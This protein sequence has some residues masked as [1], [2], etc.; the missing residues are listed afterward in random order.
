MPMMRVAH[1]LQGWLLNTFRDPTCALRFCTQ[2]DGLPIYVCLGRI[3]FDA[4][5][6]DQLLSSLTDT[7]DADNGR[8]ARAISFIQVITVR[9]KLWPKFIYLLSNFE[10]E[11]IS[12]RDGISSMQQHG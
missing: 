12:L 7:K 10:E 1:R 6:I 3:A 4:D 2:T 9:S 8:I 5:S 11:I